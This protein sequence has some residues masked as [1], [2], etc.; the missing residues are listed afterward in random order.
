[1]RA[2]N[3]LSIFFTSTIEKEV[4]S[5]TF[6]AILGFTLLVL[7]LLRW[8]HHL[9]LQEM[10]GA[11]LDVFL[12]QIF[13]GLLMFWSYLLSAI[14]AVGAVRSDEEDGVLKQ[15]LAFPLRRHEYLAA[16]LLGGF[17]LVFFYHLLATILAGWLIFR[18]VFPIGN[19]LLFSLFTIPA[20]LSIFL[21]GMIFALFFNRML[22]LLFIFFSGVMEA[23]ANYMANKV[24]FGESSIAHI[25]YWILPHGG[26][27]GKQAMDLI[28]SPGEFHIENWALESGHFIA[29][30]ALLFA[31]LS[32]LFRRRDI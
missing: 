29:S 15:L 4:R 11:S 20:L 27:W 5:K 25:I 22:S 6:L 3:I 18:D 19:Q 28:P 32:W 23:W 21:R 30:F 8:L 26:L 9:A 1:M 12:I 31:V 2:L 14:F 24:S 16:R 10:G 13:F 7:A 17:S